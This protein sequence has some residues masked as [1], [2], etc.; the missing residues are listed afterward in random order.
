VTDALLYV[1]ISRA[2]SELVVVCPRPLADR[3]DLV[4]A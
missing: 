2:V 4:V 3:L 1:G